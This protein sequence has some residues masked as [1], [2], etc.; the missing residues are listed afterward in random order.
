MHGLLL[1]ERFPPAALRSAHQLDRHLCPEAASCPAFSDLHKAV[2]KMFKNEKLFRAFRWNLKLLSILLSFV[3]VQIQSLNMINEFRFHCSHPN[4]TLNV[5]SEQ[6]SLVIC[7]SVIR[8]NSK[9]L[10]NYSFSTMENSIPKL[11]AFQNLLCQRT[12][13]S[14][15]KIQTRSC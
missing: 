15:I 2:Q 13:E 12:Q 11:I 10:Q 14:R 9:N 7:F 6:F 5:S 1:D 8:K 4:S 3:F